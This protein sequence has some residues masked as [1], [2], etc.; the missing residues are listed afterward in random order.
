M[1]ADPGSRGGLNCPDI[2]WKDNTGNLRSPGP[3]DCIDE[4]FLT[5]VMDDL[6]RG[7]T[8]LDRKPRKKAEVVEEEKVVGNCPGF[9]C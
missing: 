8:L 2:C 3:V 6:M 5:Q 9:S 4:N 7:G 1:F